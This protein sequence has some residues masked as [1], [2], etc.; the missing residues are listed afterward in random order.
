MDPS[1]LARRQFQARF[2]RCIGEGCTLQGRATPLRRDPSRQVGETAPDGG[3]WR[4][5][6]DVSVKAEPL[7]RIAKS[8][9]AVEDQI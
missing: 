1:F 9:E 7:G 5:L 6:T 8:L 4:G 3:H 2:D